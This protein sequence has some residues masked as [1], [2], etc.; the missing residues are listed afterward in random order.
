YTNGFLWTG[1]GFGFLFLYTSLYTTVYNASRTL[2][3]QNEQNAHLYQEARTQ[4]AERK[5]AEEQKQR[6]VERLAALRTIDMAITSALDL[7]V[8]L[9]TILDQACAQLHVDAASILL[10]DADAMAL[11]FAAG[12]GFRSDAIA[13]S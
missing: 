7:R 3:Q 10:L 13:Q 2:T 9:N 4:L 12:R 8:T 11:T 5:K 6:Q 1:I